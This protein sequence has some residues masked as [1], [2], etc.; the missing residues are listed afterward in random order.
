[1]VR[2]VV[3]RELQEG[4][5]ASKEKNKLDLFLPRDR[6]DF[7]VLFFVH[8]GAWR[9]GDKSYLGFYSTLAMFWARQGIGVVV[10]NYRLTPAVQHPGHIH[11]VA[12]AFAWTHKNIARYGGRPDRLFACGHS[13]G[14]HLVALLA[15][16]PAYLKTEGIKPTAI[17]GVIP[18]SGVY[19]VLPSDFR[20]YTTVFGKD[21]EVRRLAS[22]LHCVTSNA[23]PFLI[24]Y[25][26]SDFPTCGEVSE[27]FCRA[28]KAAD[29]TA[30]TLEVK[31]RN[32][33]TVL[34]RATSLDD[35][36]TQAVRKFIDTHLGNA[37][38]EVGAGDGAGQGR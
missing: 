7:P 16:D 18:I 31:E 4:E 32:H 36:V 21:P 9:H 13:A 29:C 26:D 35:P 22:P 2:D 33:V 5:D 30:E 8:G 37:G 1:M 14:G 25:A 24:I 11:D 6:K 23:P 20:L 10:T 34:L 3:Y 28:L 17:K 27:K 15:T 38:K 19:D 12:K